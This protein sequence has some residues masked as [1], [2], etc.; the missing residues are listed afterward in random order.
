VPI[1]PSSRACGRRSSTPSADPRQLRAQVD[2]VFDGAVDLRRTL[3]AEPELAG[4][5]VGTTAI[6]RERL[7]WLGLEELRCPTTT[8]A[9]FRLEGGRPGRT[10]LLRADI[11]ALPVEEETGLPFRS[12]IP[13]VMHACGHDGHTAAL[14]GAAEVLVARAADLPGRHVLLF[15][16]AEETGQG[17]RAMLEGGV[18]AGLGVERVAG[19]H[20]SSNLP[21]GLVMARPGIAMATFQ[22]FTIRLRGT[23][24]HAALAAGDGN[25]VL[26]AAELARR[27]PALLDGLELADTPCVC[28]TGVLRAGTVHNVV[29]RDAELGGS[30]RTFTDEQHPEAVARL[31]A[32]CEAVAAD[33]GVSSTVDLPRPVPAVVN[34]PAATAITRDALAAALGPASVIEAPPMTPSDDVSEFLLRAPGCYFFVGSRPGPRI[35][36]QHHAPDFDFAEEALRVAMLSLVATAEGLASS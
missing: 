28:G 5:E 21:T 36:P 24:G 29:P 26:A 30:L 17:A 31:R 23:G 33:F 6:I 18:L 15:Q 10:V 22:R 32:L 12:R 27:L 16:P 3:H 34:D 19:L 14:L 25:V 2:A 13:G 9:V 4:E 7:G 1:S 8:G 35:P 11:D 20:L